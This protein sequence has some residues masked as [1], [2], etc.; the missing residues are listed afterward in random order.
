MKITIKELRQLIKEE[1]LNEVSGTHMGAVSMIQSALDKAKIPVQTKGNTIIFRTPD[2]DY[3][4][5]T[6]KYKSRP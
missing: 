1:Y 6:I 5:M 4:E 2:L 3:W